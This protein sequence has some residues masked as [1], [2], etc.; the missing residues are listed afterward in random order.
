MALC[1]DRVEDKV[2]PVAELVDR[3]DTFSSNLS[4]DAGESLGR[5][6][7]IDPTG[8]GTHPIRAFDIVTGLER[9]RDAEMRLHERGGA[10]L[11]GARPAIIETEPLQSK[12]GTPI[13]SLQSYASPAPVERQKQRKS[14]N[15]I[16]DLF[17]GLD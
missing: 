6:T 16:D 17:Q 1:N 10:G 4:E 9:A 11:D 3:R 7:S 2:G 13:A 8:V 5:T 12:A 15:A 14:I